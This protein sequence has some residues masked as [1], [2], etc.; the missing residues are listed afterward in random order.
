MPRGVQKTPMRPCTPFKATPSS[1]PPTPAVNQALLCT[2]LGLPPSF[3]RRFS[4]SNASFTVL[5]FEG[6]GG[7]RDGGSGGSGG[8]GRGKVAPRVRVE[9]MNQASSVYLFLFLFLF[10]VC[11]SWWLA[12]LGVRAGRAAYACCC[13]RRCP[14][15]PALLPCYLHRTLLSCNPLITLHTAQPSLPVC[16]LPLSFGFSSPTGRSTLPSWA[17][18]CPTGWCSS[19]AAPLHQRCRCAGQC[20]HWLPLVGGAPLGHCMVL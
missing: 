5:D 12:R 8:G 16:L 20:R 10:S 6:E 14:G 15:S 11:A 1:H 13:A 7:Q 2:A 9:R 19:Q 4:Q 3:F 17:S 18:R